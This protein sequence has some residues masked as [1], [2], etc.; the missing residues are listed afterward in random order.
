M[1][2][3]RSPFF[4]PRAPKNVRRERSVSFET[5]IFQRTA[6]SCIWLLLYTSVD[7]HLYTN[8]RTSCSAS[9]HATGDLGMR[10]Q[11]KRTLSRRSLIAAGLSS[12]A[13][14]ACPPILRGLAEV[15]VEPQ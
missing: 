8:G 7:K 10:A 9:C 5:F 3:E 6:C 1:N 4:I 14:L 13:L 12:G 15:A 2:L 11:I